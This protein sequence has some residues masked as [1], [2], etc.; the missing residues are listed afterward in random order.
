[1]VRR[2]TARPQVLMTKFLAMK[3]HLSKFAVL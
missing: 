2:P 1:M 3:K